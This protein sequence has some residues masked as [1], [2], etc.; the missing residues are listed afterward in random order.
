MAG[1]CPAISFPLDKRNVLM[2]TKSMV[3]LRDDGEK[4]RVYASATVEVYYRG[5]VY[6]FSPENSFSCLLPK[7]VARSL[8]QQSTRGCRCRRVRFSFKP[9][10]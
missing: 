3:T 10:L 4:V 8:V 5:N 6:R 2:Y 7:D 9:L 1:K